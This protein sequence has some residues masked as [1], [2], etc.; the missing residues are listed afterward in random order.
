MAKKISEMENYAE[1]VKLC[2]YEACHVEYPEWTGEE[3]YIVFSDIP[4]QDLERLFP[5]I[6]Q[7][8]SPYIL[9]NTE[10]RKAIRKFHSLEAK[11][12]AR[13]KNCFSLDCYMK[14]SVCSTFYEDH[15]TWFELKGRIDQLTEKQKERLCRYYFEGYS[16]EEIAQ[17]ERKSVTPVA[18]SIKRA[19]KQLKKIYEGE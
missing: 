16:Y 10:I 17:Y 3:K 1:F 5:E 8:L 4:I 15:Q 12:V 9:L 2:R 18:E 7:A 11:H 13:A 14:E 19:I 6:M